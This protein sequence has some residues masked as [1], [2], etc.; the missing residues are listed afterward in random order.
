M[1]TY[2]H[3]ETARFT[4]E[5]DVGSGTHFS[6]LPVTIAAQALFHLQFRSSF[7]ITRNCRKQGFS[8]AENCLAE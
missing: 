1:V 5:N 3:E 6:T 4:A 7:L 2:V 8:I